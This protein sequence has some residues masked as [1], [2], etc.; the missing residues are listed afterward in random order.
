MHH[1][2]GHRA[3]YLKFNQEVELNKAGFELSARGKN[4]EYLGRVEITHAGVAVYTGAKGRKRL[5]NLNWEEFFE[6]MAK[7]KDWRTKRTVRAFVKRET[8]I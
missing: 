5:G 1:D 4:G 8:E 2:N 7:G 6:Q 3:G